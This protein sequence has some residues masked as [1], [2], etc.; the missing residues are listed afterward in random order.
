MKMKIQYPIIYTNIMTTPL[1]NQNTIVYI[2]KLKKLT[3]HLL[4]YVE[5]QKPQLS[6]SLF[7]PCTHSHVQTHFL[8]VSHA[9]AHSCHAF[10][11]TCIYIYVYIYMLTLP[12]PKSNYHSIH[13]AKDYFSSFSP[14]TSSKYPKC[15]S[16]L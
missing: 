16:S 7:K 10:Y 11:L 13:K 6:S 15:P 14:P 1:H 8:W 2:K 5:G 3:W 4:S 9:L 12:K